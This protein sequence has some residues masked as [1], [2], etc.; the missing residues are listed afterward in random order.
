[1][2]RGDTPIRAFSSNTC[3]EILEPQGQPEGTVAV[4][5]VAG[6][7]EHVYK[8]MQMLW[9]RSRGVF[10]AVPHKMEGF[11]RRSHNKKVTKINNE[12]A[13]AHQSRSRAPPF[14]CAACAAEAFEASKE[15]VDRGRTPS[16]SHVKP[17]VIAPG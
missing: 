4:P 10:E 6:R 5:T 12:T 3:Q 2:E 7:S 11:C 16:P 14:R 13:S 1:M 8:S 9:S 17:L 15:L